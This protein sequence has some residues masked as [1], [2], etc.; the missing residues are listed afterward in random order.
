MK[1]IIDPLKG[2]ICS[3][4]GV[5]TRIYVAA[6]IG[7]CAWHFRSPYLAI[8]TLPW[9]GFML[10]WLSIKWDAEP[11]P[12]GD[13]GDPSRT[14]RG[15]AR[16]LRSIYQTPDER[17]PGDI[18][19][20]AVGAWLQR[21]GKWICAYLWGGDRNVAQG[22]GRVLG[23]EVSGYMPDGGD[24]YWSN[25]EVWRY[26]WPVPTLV[27]LMCALGV[28]YAGFFHY[29]LLAAALFLACAWRLRIVVGWQV[30][31]ALDGRF[32]GVPLFTV[33]HA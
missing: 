8:L 23:K 31:R 17:Y 30:I 9:I 27:R 2:L 25:G 7:F 19:Q 11:S 4:F 20:P 16:L 3:L 33:K 10:S 24:G 6:I 22:L 14:I 28:G 29:Y 13:G 26:D 15:D 1:F 32:I 21:F 18:T 12:G 5:F